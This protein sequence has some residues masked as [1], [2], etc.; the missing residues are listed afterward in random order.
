MG[1]YLLSLGSFK[2]KFQAGKRVRTY[3]NDYH[4]H[5]DELGLIKAIVTVR[6]S[7]TAVVESIVGKYAYRQAEKQKLE[8][9]QYPPH[10]IFCDCK[11][12]DPQEWLLTRKRTRKG[13]AN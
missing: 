1:A 3:E 13:K 10:S 2:M 5:L 6:A 12:C 9:E 8:I 11:G 7:L 4:L